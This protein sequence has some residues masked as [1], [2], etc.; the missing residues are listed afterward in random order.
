LRK[1]VPTQAGYANG[2]RE[3]GETD[4]LVITTGNT[5]AD[6]EKAPPIEG[7]IGRETGR[8]RHCREL[9]RLDL[10]SSKGEKG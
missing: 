9:F 1:N 7:R 3:R 2:G 8:L 6:S 5:R 10:D 4:L